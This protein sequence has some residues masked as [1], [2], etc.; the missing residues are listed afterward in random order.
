M[1]EAK[2]GNVLASEKSRL[3]ACFYL[4]EK[5]QLFTLD[6]DCLIRLWD[7]I[8]GNC[9]RSYPL[10]VI[11]APDYAG[12]GQELVGVA[13]HNGVIE[14]TN[15]KVQFAKLEPYKKRLVFVALEGGY[16]QVN[17]VYSGAVVYNKSV[18]DNLSLEHEISDILF[19][20]EGGKQ[21]AGV[22]CWD[23]FV[24]FISQPRVSNGVE[25]IGH[26]TKSSSHIGDIVSV[27]VTKR[28]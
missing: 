6:Q 5:G 12:E 26:T 17:N 14:P 9:L 25:S 18:V 8:D 20:K 24:S 27:D 3:A 7:L 2:A 11:E 23:G 10:E 15:R 28:D 22:A 13:F 21:C 4:P 1:P 19:F 16:L